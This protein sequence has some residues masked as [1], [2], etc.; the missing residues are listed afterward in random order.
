MHLA[1]PAYSL[2]QAACPSVCPSFSGR[3]A[4]LVPT[5]Q[6]QQ[7]QVPRELLGMWGPCITAL[8]A[9]LKCC[10]EHTWHWVVIS[11]LR[12]SF[13]TVSTNWRG[14]KKRIKKKEK[15]LTSAVPLMLCSSDQTRFSLIIHCRQSP[16][17][18][19]RRLA[20][21]MRLHCS[22]LLPLGLPMGGCNHP[23]GEALLQ[24]PASPGS[25]KDCLF[26]ISSE[27]KTNGQ[28]TTQFWYRAK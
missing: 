7:L 9:N 28:K 2:A 25:L 10:Q 13:S 20:A 4:A 6:E 17:P 27:M 19:G 11:D 5:F 3:F 16:S 8:T 15:A 24:G 1:A 14:K 21:E 22:S 26:L 18:Y 12:V 23:P